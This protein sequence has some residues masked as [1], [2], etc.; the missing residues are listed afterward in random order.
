MSRTMSSKLAQKPGKT[1]P[2]EETPDGP[3][4]LEIL[5]GARRVFRAEG[6]D[7]A[8]MDKIAQ[9]AGVSKGTVYVYFRNKEELFKEMVRVDRREAAEQLCQFDDDAAAGDVAT[10]LQRVGESFVAMMI[11]PEHIALIRMVMGA[12]E[13]FPEAGRVFFDMGP[14]FGIRRLAAYL[15]KQV[16]AGTLSIDEEI[17]LASAHFLNLCQGNLVKPLLFCAGEAPGQEKIRKT[18]A[19]AVRVFMKVYGVSK[20]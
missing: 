13:K 12:A 8:S 5:D 14:C 15:E 4:K 7:G 1:P 16:A 2:A 17:E 10:D 19:S 9:A 11:R 20:P 6:F 3:K 18:V